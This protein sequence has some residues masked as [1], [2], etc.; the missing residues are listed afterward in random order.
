MYNKNPKWHDCGLSYFGISSEYTS[1]DQYLSFPSA[2]LLRSN[3]TPFACSLYLFLI[4][5]CREKISIV[6]RRPL[7]MLYA[8]K[9]HS[10]VN[11][12]LVEPF[13]DFNICYFSRKIRQLF[14]EKLQKQ[15]E[16]YCGRQVS[17]VHKSYVELC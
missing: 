10:N 14:S 17:K 13:H 12:S 4:K 16:Y 1:F 8:Q 11:M 5:N 2:M 6:G 7:Q 15:C 3:T 9:G